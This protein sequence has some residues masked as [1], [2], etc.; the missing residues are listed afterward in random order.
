MHRFPVAAEGG[1]GPAAVSRIAALA[2]SAEPL[3]DKAE[4]VLDEVQRIFPF[5]AAILS[6]VDLTHATR[7][8]PL[9]FRGYSREFADYLVSEEW[10]AECVA[11]FG[12]PRSGL[13]FREADLSIDPL[14]LEGVVKGR[15]L[16]LNEGLLSALINSRGR[17]TGFLMC[18]WSETAAP[19]EEA[20]ASIG[21]IAEALGN[22]VDP[23]G[24]ALSVASTLDEETT[25][26]AV[27]ADATTVPLRG[28]SL[29]SFLTSESPVMSTIAE[30]SFREF[31]STS[32]LW[33]APTGGWFKCWVYPC[34]D[35]V[36]L[37]LSRAVDDAC[38]LTRRELEVVTGL[39]DGCSNAE[40]AARLWI[41][42]RT[43]RAHVE[44][45]LEKLG[46][47]TRAAAVARAVGEG[48]RL[49]RGVTTIPQDLAVS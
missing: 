13:P 31:G 7:T 9:A 5:D 47:T 16:N 36:T 35:D 14:S 34:A 8:R 22:M 2:T 26:V 48:L 43:A 25:A 18:S 42:T 11:P 30:G 3:Q 32:F 39:V 17:H 1:N 44:H 21:Q 23:L 28:T 20:C 40:I 29:P 12:L 24:S 33:P 19:P 37:W 10:H 27:L 45:I 6:C 46:V 41:T 15:S 49:P 38:G 4:Q